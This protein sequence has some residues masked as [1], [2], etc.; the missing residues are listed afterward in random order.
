MQRKGKA[1]Q[2][3]ADLR[4]EHGLPGPMDEARAA[5]A[6]DLNAKMEIIL[7]NI[8]KG[9]FLEMACAVALVDPKTFRR[10][11]KK[12]Q[13]GHEPY[14]GFLLQV[15][16][17]QAV[18]I[19]AMN[20]VIISAALRGDWKAAAWRLEKMYPQKYG[21]RIEIADGSDPYAIDA[22]NDAG[23]DTSRLSVEDKRRAR[24]L[25][26]KLK[27]LPTQ[28]SSVPTEDGIIDAEVVEE[29]AKRSKARPKKRPKKV[30]KAAVASA[31][32]ASPSSGGNGLAGVLSS[33]RKGRKA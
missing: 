27:G 21:A 26:R 19:G 14:R 1:R 31:A 22:A 2:L 30:I 5:L 24:E 3:A 20:D 32:E 17:S 11:L 29:P 15:R 9:E 18:A 10:W 8:E 7:R 12:G 13:A 23:A 6:D 25:Q 4:K 16:K 33:I 28:G